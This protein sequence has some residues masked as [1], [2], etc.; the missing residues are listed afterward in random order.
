MCKYR[1]KKNQL[2]MADC[3]EARYRLYNHKENVRNIN[4]KK[5]STIN[6]CPSKNRH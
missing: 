2:I 6:I 4:T 5:M 1:I 3:D